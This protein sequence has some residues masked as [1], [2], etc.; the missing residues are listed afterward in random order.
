MASVVARETVPCS[1]RTAA[2]TP[3]STRFAVGPYATA[4]PS[5]TAE[6]PSGV[7]SRSARMPAL[8]D[9]ATAMVRPAAV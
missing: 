7:A 6:A 1:S 9:S 8:A 2:S 4:P 3:A 5:S